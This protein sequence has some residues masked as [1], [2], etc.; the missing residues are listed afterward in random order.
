[1]GPSTG[2]V[3]VV[4]T[5]AEPDS[6][7][8]FLLA[9]AGLEPVGDDGGDG[10]DALDLVDP[11]RDVSVRLIAGPGE[12][13]AR[14]GGWLTVRCGSAD[15]I[16][17]RARRAA[18]DGWDVRGPV[19]SQD[20][21]GCVA[22][23]DGPDGCTVELIWRQSDGADAASGPA[24]S[25]A[26]PTP[27]LFLPVPAGP[28]R[29]PLL[30]LLLSSGAPDDYVCDWYQ[31]G[32]MFALADALADADAPPAGVAHALPVGSGRTVELRLF[33]V[34]PEHR[35][36]GLGHRLLAELADHLR[37]SGTRRLVAGLADS[38]PA[39]MTL[40]TR[41]GFRFAHVERDAATI[42]R[43]APVRAATGQGFVE[44]GPRPR[45]LIWFDLEL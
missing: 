21:A 2:L 31:D 40:L 42:Q 36:R 6:V 35:G 5:V 34:A 13:P 25:P 10:A 3:G 30:P 44:P 26:V 45:D 12:G 7:A 37:A 9:H 24:R 28:E 23:I 18:D 38:D 15:E 14:A 43:G 1:M 39:R 22:W 19:G 32:E 4:L 16:E 41:V 8:P 33:V 29:E 27:L 20:P 11:S 17:R